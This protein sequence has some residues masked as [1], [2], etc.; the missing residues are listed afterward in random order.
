MELGISNHFFIVCGAGSGFGR[1]VAEALLAE[2]AHILAISRN[3]E[4]LKVLQATGAS[5]VEYVAGDITNSENI[6][7]L[8]EKTA[9]RQI[10]GILVN[11]GGPPAR[12]V[13]ESSLQDWDA[14]YQSLLR[15][16]VELSQVFVPRMVKAGYGRL[17]YIES[18]TVKQPLENLVLSNSLR[19]AVTGFVKTFS[20]EIARSGVTLN[21]LAPGSHDTAAIERFYKKKSEQTQLPVDE[22]RKR[23]VESIPVG[24]LGDPKDLASLATWLLSP[25]S[26][27]IT[28]QTISVDGGQVKSIFG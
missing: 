6:R 20:Q 22:I 1:A 5:R 27:Y 14:A 3:E 18:S 24:T 28:G 19:A 26:R 8:A 2:G 17:V 4:P 10:H 16:K 7:L 12:T 13:M 11:A 9:G 23:A 21:V 25:S 15:W